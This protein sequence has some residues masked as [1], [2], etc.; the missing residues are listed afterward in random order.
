MAIWAHFCSL[1]PVLLVPQ[2]SWWGIAVGVEMDAQMTGV[3]GV[4]AVSG[5]H[6]CGRG[7]GMWQVVGSWRHE[8]S[9]LL[10]GSLW[11][12]ALLCR[13]QGAVDV[14]LLLPPSSAAMEDG[15]RFPGTDATSAPPHQAQC[16]GHHD[17]CTT[18][19]AVASGVH[20]RPLALSCTVS[21]CSHPDA[22]KRG[23]LRCLC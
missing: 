15:P 2:G 9:V 7:G 13:S 11:C 10:L 23:S 3:V 12:L 21:Q 14:F 22:L 20:L 6:H 17:P 8:P 18:A 4:P 5:H 16:A 19:L 1:S